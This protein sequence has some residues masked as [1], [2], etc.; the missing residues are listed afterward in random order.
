MCTFLKFP[1]Q[2]IYLN[3]PAFNVSLLFAS[4]YIVMSRKAKKTCLCGIA[5]IKS[6]WTVTPVSPYTSISSL[7]IELNCHSSPGAE[8]VLHYPLARVK[9]GKKDID[10]I[11]NSDSCFN[12]F[13]KT[14]YSY[15]HPDSA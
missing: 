11:Q 2:A 3:R 12:I 1:N 14:T 5:D 7:V 6:S 4:L 13:S 8:T 10:F 9:T 15:C